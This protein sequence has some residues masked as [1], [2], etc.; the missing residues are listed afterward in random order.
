MAGGGGSPCLY[1]K[2]DFLA[3]D[4]GCVT[5]KLCAP[6]IYVI[7][8]LA[9]KSHQAPRSVTVPVLLMVG[10]VRVHF[11]Y[12]N[13]KICNILELYI[14]HLFTGSLAGIGKL[15]YR[16]LPVGIR[17]GMYSIFCTVRFSGSSIL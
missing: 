3:A 8:L 13:P 9:R 15:R 1:Q 2:A 10:I 16:H 7:F 4:F 5:K 6:N 17:Y 11:L 14:S 12:L